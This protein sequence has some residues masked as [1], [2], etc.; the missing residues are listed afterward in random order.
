MVG[1][2]SRSSAPLKLPMHV[3]KAHR[4]DGKHQSPGCS[5]SGTRSRVGVGE[6]A[7]I[8]STKGG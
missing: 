6:G 8:P 1:Q 4:V 3:E 7:S 5:G 2:N